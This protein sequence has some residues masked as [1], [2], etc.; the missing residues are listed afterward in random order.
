MAHVLV[1]K[2]KQKE[3]HINLQGMIFT[4]GSLGIIVFMCVILYNLDLYVTRGRMRW[5]KFSAISGPMV[6]AAAV[7]LWEADK[8][9]RLIP[10]F[11]CAAH[12]IPTSSMDGHIPVG[13]STRR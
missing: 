4:W 13:S 7:Q 1:P 9:D 11:S 8:Q 2:K 6:S 5:V 10:W 12:C 3:L